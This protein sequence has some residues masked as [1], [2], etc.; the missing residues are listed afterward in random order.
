[1]PEHTYGPLHFGFLLISRAQCRVIMHVNTYTKVMFLSSVDDS[2]DD[3]LES[4]L[5]LVGNHAFA[6]MEG[7]VDKQR[8]LIL[9]G[10]VSEAAQQ[11][12]HQ[13]K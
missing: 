7:D 5:G 8:K 1:M 11:K 2:G 10:H 3:S 4:D 9:Q 6:R 12:Q 13:R